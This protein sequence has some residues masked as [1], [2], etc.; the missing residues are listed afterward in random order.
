MEFGSYYCALG[1]ATANKKICSLRRCKKQAQ[2]APAGIFWAVKEFPSP[3][4][5][6]IAST[7][8]P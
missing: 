3:Y 6:V 7:E 8:D 5:W 1:S 4:A 2:S